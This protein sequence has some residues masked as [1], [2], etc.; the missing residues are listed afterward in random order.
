MIEPLT[1]LGLAANIVQLVEFGARVIDAGREIASQGSTQEQRHLKRLAAETSSIC[2]QIKR[3]ER[4]VIGRSRF[5]AQDGSTFASLATQTKSVANNLD[6]L[7]ARLE[8]NAED[9]TEGPPTKRQRVSSSRVARKLLRGIWDDKEIK[10]LKSRML[11][12]QR[13]LLLELANNQR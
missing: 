13:Q 7:L 12:L 9:E 8:V 1:A 5:S 11:D 3:Q 6:E 2:D 10:G 4:Q